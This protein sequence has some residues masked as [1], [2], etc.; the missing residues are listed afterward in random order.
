MTET[1]EQSQSPKSNSLGDAPICK[2]KK[3]YPSFWRNLKDY[4][5][6]Y[7][8]STSLH[9]FQY[10]GDQKRSVIE[11]LHRFED[12][13]L[14]CDSHL[15][16]TGRPITD[17]N[18]VDF[19]EEVAPTFKE[20]LWQCIWQSQ[21]ETCDTMFVPMLSEEGICYTF[22]MLD[23]DKIYRN[24]VYHNKN[25]LK[26]TYDTEDWSL[27]NG[28]AEDVDIETYPRRAMTAGAKAGLSIL[29]RSFIQHQDFVCRG[30]VQGF[31]VSLHN[32][33]EIPRV[34]NQFFRAPLNQEIIVAIKPDM[35]TTSTGLQD[36]DPHRRGCYFAKE[37]PLRYFKEYTQQNCDMEC[38]TNITYNLCGCVSFYMPHAENTPICGSG[39]NQCVTEAM[40]TMVSD[41]SANF[42]CDC[43]PACTTLSYNAETSQA[44]FNWKD[45]LIAFKAN[46]SEFP[47]IQ[48]SRLRLL[49]KEMQFI[50]SER[51]ELYGITDFM[52]N[53]GGLLGLFIGFSFVSL[54]ETVYFLT[55]R[56]WVN[57]KGYGVHFWSAS[58]ELLE[59][60]A[61]VHPYKHK[62]QTSVNLN[63]IKVD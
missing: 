50:N 37:R 60:D 39:S 58:D 30:P 41:N 59:N 34:G 47:G 13:S 14:L 49:F 62:E 16:K 51:N 52:A 45:M 53:C 4:F 23:R 31:K 12:I 42:S 44:D 27:E 32:P 3:K 26:V 61:Y 8:S 57:L 9:G 15:V 35:I 18:V 36:Y 55:L 63:C 19:Y 46:L 2:R 38:Q 1:A 29:L 10:L 6:E 40:I 25:F 7:T 28:Y 5:S 20:T 22:N 11:K 54:I 56:L 33:G 17:L 43:L 21:N 24:E 48:M